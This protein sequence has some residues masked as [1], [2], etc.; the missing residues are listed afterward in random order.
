MCCSAVYWH[1][2]E[3]EKHQ[4]RG[5]GVRWL[6]ENEHKRPE[7]KTEPSEW[8]QLCLHLSLDFTYFGEWRVSTSEGRAVCSVSDMWASSCKHSEPSH[9]FPWLD[10][11]YFHSRGEKNN[12]SLIPYLATQHTGL[13][14]NTQSWQGRIVKFLSPF[15]Y[16][17]VVIMEELNF[18][19]CSFPGTRQNKPCFLRTPWI[20]HCCHCLSQEMMMPTWNP[21]ACFYYVCQRVGHMMRVNHQVIQSKAITQWL[22]INNDFS[23]FRTS[24]ATLGSR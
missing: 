16:S 12:K 13:T 22:M 24:R 14:D 21:L 8:D 6:N 19:L 5:G 1:M 3:L 17:H 2:A 4:G 9:L 20:S 11:F 7:T 18:C 15:L 23:I 10:C